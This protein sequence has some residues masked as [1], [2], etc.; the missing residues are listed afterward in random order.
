MRRDTWHPASSS[1]KNF[2]P[3]TLELQLWPVWENFL[4]ASPRL[5]SRLPD[6]LPLLQLILLLARCA[7]DSAALDLQDPEDPLSG[8]DVLRL[9]GPGTSSAPHPVFP[10]TLGDWEG[11]NTTNFSC[12]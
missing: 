6:L 7:H 8:R 11:D 9:M 2:V 10:R 5:A 3:T 1:T 4:S 12:V